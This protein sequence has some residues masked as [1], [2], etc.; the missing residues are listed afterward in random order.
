MRPLLWHYLLIVAFLPC[1][2]DAQ[3]PEQPA[4][5]NLKICDPSGAV[6]PL[7]W[8]MVVPPPNPAARM[9]M[10]SQDGKL[11]LSLA[12]GHYC[13]TVRKMGFKQARQELDAKAGEQRSISITLILGSCTQCVEVRGIPV[14]AFPDQTRG[15]SP[16]GRY[17]LLQKERSGRHIVEI[18]DRVLNTRRIL[19]Q[20]HQRVV[21]SWVGSLILATDYLDDHTS[22]STIYSTDKSTPPIPVWDL[23]KSQLEE[24]EKL[25]L[26]EALR[27]K[28]VQVRG[29]P[30]QGG[31]IGV[32]VH[33]YGA[34]G[35]LEFQWE[36]HLTLPH[37]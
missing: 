29:Y 17:L 4:A 7:A 13:L 21:L 26:E 12:P 11:S 24:D 2:L 33:A 34:T 5:I 25:G 28:R 6:V 8:V 18:K 19:M 31:G 23:L 37:D 3:Q 22:E 10:T 27:S 9:L 35:E 32:L 36:Y 16:D 14:L 30:D 1:T 15:S 20:Y